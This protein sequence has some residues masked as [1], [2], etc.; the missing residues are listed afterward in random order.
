SWLWLVG[1]ALAVLI[2]A[3]GLAARHSRAARITAS[4]VMTVWA[5]ICGILGLLVAALA[6]TDHKFAHANE[7]LLVFHPLWLIVALT[8]PMLLAGGRARVLTQRLLALFVGLG[9]IALL[10]HL[11]GLSRQSHMAFVALALS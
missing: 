9:A 8:V 5:S 4:I 7:N 2:V 10:I 11:V 6:F 3:L 1:A